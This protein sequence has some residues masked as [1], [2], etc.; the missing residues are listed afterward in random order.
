MNPTTL[1][2]GSIWNHAGQ[3]TL[4]IDYTSALNAGTRVTATSAPSGA[5]GGDNVLGYVSVIDAGGIGMARWDGTNIVR[6]DTT[7]LTATTCS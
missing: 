7:T 3:S 2:L 4:S 6:F 5:T 1:A